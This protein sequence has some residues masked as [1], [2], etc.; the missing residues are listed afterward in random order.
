MECDGIHPLPTK[1]QAI[2]DFPQPTSRR[3]LR[4]FLGLINFYHRF[5]PGC[6]KILDPLNSLLSS[7]K[8][9][10]SWD[11][12]T[13]QAFSAIKEALAA[14]TLLV[15]PKPNALTS[16]MT[17]ASDSAVGAVLQQYI[18]RQRQPILFFSKKLK[19][20]ETRYSTFD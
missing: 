11:N 9:H 16:L 5:V 17:D 12:T 6:A 20:S 1:V 19:L 10:L 14:A 4:T 8:E 3:Q 7:S 2:I 13:S 15:H 18:N